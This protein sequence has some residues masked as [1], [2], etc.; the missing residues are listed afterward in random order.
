[1]KRYSLVLPFEASPRY[2]R[3]R[4]ELEHACAKLQFSQLRNGGWSIDGVGDEN[5]SGLKWSGDDNE[6]FFSCLFHFDFRPT[7]SF[8]WLSFRRQRLCR[9]GRVFL[10]KFF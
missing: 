2:F 5:R 6:Q 3:V 9:V 8:L 10:K 1:M 7:S 4:R